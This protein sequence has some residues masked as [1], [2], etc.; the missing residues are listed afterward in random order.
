MEQLRAQNAS[1]VTEN[2]ELAAMS[3][4][5]VHDC[6]PDAGAA[7]QTEKTCQSCQTLGSFLPISAHLLLSQNP[8]VA[9][10]FTHPADTAFSFEPAATWRPPALD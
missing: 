5:N 2:P 7:K 3:D 10:R 1:V 6:C 9:V 8:A 4:M